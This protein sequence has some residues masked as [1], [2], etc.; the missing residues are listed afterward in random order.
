[1]DPIKEAFGDT[2]CYRVF[3]VRMEAE[4]RDRLLRAY[5]VRS[6]RGGRN[7]GAPRHPGAVPCSLMREDLAKL[8]TRRYAAL[9]KTDGTRY[10]LIAT[11]CGRD[12][13]TVVIDRACKVRIVRVGFAKA[14]HERDTLFDGELVYNEDARR[15]EFRVFDCIA[16]RGRV[17]H[18]DPYERRMSAAR[19]MM[20]DEYRHDARKDTFLVRVKHYEVGRDARR[21]TERVRR[22]DG[23]PA[24]GLVLVDLDAPVRLRRNLDMYKW[25]WQHTVD[26]LVVAPTFQR[27]S[28]R[29][30]AMLLKNERDVLVHFAD[31]DA[32]ANADFLRRNAQLI[33][34]AG[35][36][37]VVV[38]CVPAQS[39]APPVRW[40]LD[41]V[42]SDRRSPNCLYTVERTE[43]NVLE[44][45]TLDD[46]LEALDPRAPP[47]VVPRVNATPASRPSTSR[48]RAPRRRNEPHG[49]QSPRATT[50]T[51]PVP[52]T[53]RTQCTPAHAPSLRS[54]DAPVACPFFPDATPPVPRPV[55]T[56]PQSMAGALGS[57]TCRTVAGDWVEMPAYD[58]MEPAIRV[59]S[60]AT[61]SRS[62]RSSPT[63]SPSPSAHDSEPPAKRARSDDP[64]FAQ[65]RDGAPT[66]SMAPVRDAELLSPRRLRRLSE[67]L[68]ASGACG[69]AMG[70][71]R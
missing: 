45:I 58:P 22:D 11:M 61:S 42:R 23:A 51:E 10:S 17:A 43:R 48:R 34:A 59:P 32:R 1:M 69:E 41:R 20:A 7:D 44:A 46:V 68:R 55:I 36:A 47:P 8:R 65:P 40:V 62:S 31:V 9:P 64:H 52:E 28:A 5:G 3:D 15:H 37:G 19:A 13:W 26:V 6:G 57:Q 38:E 16:S 50:A 66:Q 2:H 24:D 25:K 54:N 60:R 29:A 67:A 49:G 18:S 71:T 70:A 4:F 39:G 21:L 35:R 30:Y 56:D 14:V 27:S 53:G 63:R 12:A 33:E